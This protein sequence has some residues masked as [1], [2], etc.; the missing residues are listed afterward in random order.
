MLG[1]KEE[2]GRNVPTTDWDC[3]SQP[4]FGGWVH[5]ENGRCYRGSMVM[6]FLS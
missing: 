4:R 3:K 5:R 1:L 6:R 2:W